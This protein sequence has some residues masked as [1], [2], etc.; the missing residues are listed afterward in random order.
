MEHAIK[1]IDGVTLLYGDEMPVSEQNRYSIPTTTFVL[2]M[3]TLAGRTIHY[4][5]KVLERTGESEISRLL[6][7]SWQAS[8]VRERVLA[9]L[10]TVRDA[11][12]IDNGALPDGCLLFTNEQ[13][14]PPLSCAIA[15]FQSGAKVTFEDYASCVYQALQLLEGPLLRRIVE[16]AA[17]R[18]E[19]FGAV[20]RTY[21]GKDDW[22]EAVTDAVLAGTIDELLASS[23]G[24]SI[25]RSQD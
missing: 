16:G 17:S 1:T 20:C 10:A 5:G 3:K 15:V 9:H 24:L 22:R 6:V 12:S 7:W 13:G 18:E 8:Y 23:R 11:E 2:A 19:V 14:V 25:S 4:P 21:R